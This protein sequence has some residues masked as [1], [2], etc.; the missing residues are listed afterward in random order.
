MSATQSNEIRKPLRRWFA[1]MLLVILLL[2]LNRALATVTVTAA[3]GGPAI[4]ADSTGGTYTLLTGPILQESARGSIGTGT[5]IL[6]V[7]SGFMFN[8]GANSVTATVTCTGAGGALLA[9]AST[10][11]TPT[12]TT[13]TITVTTA[14]GGSRA[15]TIT[16]S[17]IQVRP[18]AG[19]PLAS[20]TIT[21][22][23][24]SSYTVSPA[25]TAAQYGQLTEVAGAASK[26]GFS[27]QPGNTVA[28]CPS[29]L[30]NIAG[31]PTVV[32]Q[33]QFA[34]ALGVGS[35]SIS[36]AIGTNPSA[37]TLTGTASV[38]ASAG[39]AVFSQLRIDTAGTGYTLIAS[40]AGLT[41]ATSNA[42]NIAVSAWSGFLVQASGGGNIGTQLQ[43]TAFNIQVT[44]VDA[45][46]NTVTTYVSN[47]TISSSCTLSSG[48]GATPNFTA[49]VLNPRSV[50][51]SSSGTCTITATS[52]A[53]SGTS[54][55]FTV[56]PFGGLPPGGYF[57]VVE[58]GATPATSIFTKVSAQAFS[59]DVLALDSGGAVLSSFSG[60]VSAEIVDSSSGT[61]AAMS[62]IA[63]LPNQTFSGS[64][65]LT[66][67][68]SAIDVTNAWKNGRFRIKYPAVSP[69]IT[70]CSSDNF[71]IRPAS[72]TL[73]S[74]DATW[75]TAGTGRTLSNTTATGGNVHAAGQPFTLTVSP[76]PA[77]ATNYDTTS[78]TVT[79]GYPACNLPGSCTLGTLSLGT[80][81]A[82]GSGV[83]ASS[84]AG[85]AEVGAIDLQLEDGDFAAVDAGDTS[86]S[87]TSPPT[88]NRYVC[89]NATLPIGR[90]VP[91]H[92]DV[93]TANTPQF[94]TFGAS[95]SGTRSFTYI[96]QPFNYATRPQATILA[97][98]AAGATTANYAGT[99][100][101]IGGATPSTA[102]D[103]LASPN[104]DT[105]QFTTSWAAAGNSSNVIE[106]YTYVL[107]PASTPNWDNPGATPVAATVTAGTGVN[108][109]TGIITYAASDALAFLR[110]TTTP[111]ATFTASITNT[112]SV[113][114]TSEN[115]VVGNGTIAT[116]TAAAFGSIAF[117]AGN[118]FRYG[119]MQF[120]NA[121]GSGLLAL[122]MPIQ[123]EYWNGT[124]W[125]RNASDNCTSVNPANF[126]LGNVTGFTSTSASGGGTLT[127]GGGRITLAK[128]TGGTNGTVDVTINLGATGTAN[129][130]PCPVWAPAPA[131][132]ALNAPYLEGQC[133]GA[134]TYNRDPSA[135]ATFGIYRN[136]FILL[137]ENY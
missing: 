128:P 72:I 86:G 77:T 45:C 131:A 85:Y 25:L 26:L 34:N 38:T 91:D 130:N 28:G 29:A 71:A 13:I 119:R 12:S 105:C 55:S 120:M 32:I 60:S 104:P 15:C 21:E 70:S 111:Q 135:R 123:V 118:E 100:W 22:N 50:T 14:S 136:R 36:M 30:N 39:V 93:S 63:L 103:C 20:G 35:Q 53:T 101:K 116:A 110:N 33:D 126:A 48:S 24:T 37:G 102:K 76:Q 108:A 75:N 74:T 69:T 79:S 127:G 133:A 122:D 65:R 2:F 47:A 114:D 49:G 23:G 17:G 62:Q 78:F 44:A 57:D 59:V 66:M 132:T 16:Y 54:N 52:G 64:G 92:F 8:T 124:L 31:P 5:I 46:L 82:A 137:R 40:S 96:G 61:C 99:L 88:P 73:S 7:P 90:F 117:D 129:A 41:S 89:S 115:A 125:L 27:I 95:C 134:G 80:F 42:F 19:S 1:P 51:I 10:T 81:G 11:V 106:S 6:N 109:G 4:S 68:V 67:S 58:V 107:T 94:Q 112:I 98:N 18:T 83:Q 56:N 43:G 3:S 97:R 84:T 9:L 87:C 113:Q 121:H